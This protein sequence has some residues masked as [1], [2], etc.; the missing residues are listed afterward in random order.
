MRNEGLEVQTDLGSP[1]LV[2]VQNGYTAQSG[3]MSNPQIATK[4]TIAD[5]TN[6][7]SQTTY[8]YD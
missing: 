5:D 1:A 2:T 8:Q 4:T 7:V 3:C 6:Q